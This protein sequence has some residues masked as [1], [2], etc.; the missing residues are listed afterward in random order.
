M[1]ILLIGIEEYEHDSIN[2][3]DR[4]PDVNYL[5]AIG[6][7]RTFPKHPTNKFRNRT[8]LSK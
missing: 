7:R 4:N 2:G 6:T 3:D 5:L 8:R 1:L